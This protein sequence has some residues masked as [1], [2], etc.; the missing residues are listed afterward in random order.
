MIERTVA[1]TNATLF[2]LASNSK[3]FTAVLGMHFE[4]MDYKINSSNSDY[5]AFIVSII[6]VEIAIV[7]T[8]PDQTSSSKT[9]PV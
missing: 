9:K 1:V 6:P 8:Q 3:L 4:M 7:N 5:V 2:S